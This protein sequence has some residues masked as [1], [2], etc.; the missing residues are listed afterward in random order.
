[1]VMVSFRIIQHCVWIHKKP[2]NGF[3]VLCTGGTMLELF[4]DYPLAQAAQTTQNNVK[5]KDDC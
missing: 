5:N 1:M 3:F 2:G 4:Q